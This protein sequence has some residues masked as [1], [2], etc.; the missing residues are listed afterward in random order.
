[1]I[2]YLSLNMVLHH[3]I[4]LKQNHAKAFTG[5]GL[6]VPAAFVHTTTGQ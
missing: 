2:A 5:A 1:M 4:I 3:N 6:S